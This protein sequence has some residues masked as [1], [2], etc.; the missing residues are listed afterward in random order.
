MQEVSTEREIE[1]PEPVRDIYRLWRPPRCT[2]RAAGEG[3]RHPGQDLLQV[4]GREPGGSHKPNTAVAAG[5]LQQAGGRQA[6]HHRDRRRPV[7]HVAGVRRRCSASRCTVFMVRV[8]Y[9]QKPYRRALM[10]TYGARCTAVAVERDRAAAACSRSARPPGQPG[11]RD[12]GGGR[13]RGAARRH[14]VRARL[15]A[16]P[17]AAAP[18]DHRPGGDGSSW[19]WPT[20]I[21]TWWSAAPAAAR[22]SP[23]SPSRSSATQLRGGKQAAHRRG[24]AGGLPVADA[25][26]V[27]LRLRRH[28]HMTPLTKMHTLGSPSR[29]RASTPAACATTAWR[30][31]CRTEGARPDRGDRLHQTASASRPACSSRAPK[32]SCPRPRPTTRSRARSTR[33]CAA[34]AR[35]RARRSCSTSAATATSTCRPTSKYFA[36][37]SRTRPTTRRNWRWR[38]R[39]CRAW[40]S[41]S[42][43]SSPPMSMATMACSRTLGLAW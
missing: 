25:R 2:A 35:A 29:R 31:W 36:G 4:R 27:R 38:W 10:E 17:R 23:A 37:N 33:R 22:T 34:S 1:I 9:D 13:G 15:G 43:R 28:R 12:L 18:D 5:L 39:A 40:N 21:P 11:H 32:A 8:S 42:R 7:G 20:P 19:R 30:R 14:Q 3:A 26:Q 16:Q 41:S 6:P 24:R